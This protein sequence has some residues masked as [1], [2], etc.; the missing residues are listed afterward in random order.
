MLVIFCQPILIVLITRKLFSQYLEDRGFL[1][2]S[3][4]A[5]S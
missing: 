5:P 1:I 3:K 4:P 2:V